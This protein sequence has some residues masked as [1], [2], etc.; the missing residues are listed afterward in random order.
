MQ[1][2][3]H[4]KYKEIFQK[5]FGLIARID[6]A[7]VGNFSLD[8]SCGIHT[9]FQLM[10]NSSFYAKPLPLK[11]EPIYP[12]NDGKCGTG[13]L[14]DEASHQFAAFANALR[15]NYDFLSGLLDPKNGLIQGV[16]R[17]EGVTG[18]FPR[19]FVRKIDRKLPGEQ[20]EKLQKP[21]LKL[22]PKNRK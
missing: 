15:D 4:E 17:V 11:M 6:A 10:T 9:S 8:F 22:L 14:Q 21:S 18:S 5:I 16:R 20:V 13:R 12:P 2:F 1:I 19:N 3:V 7:K